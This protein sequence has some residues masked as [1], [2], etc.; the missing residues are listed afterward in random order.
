[1]SPSLVPLEGSLSALRPSSWFSLQEHHGKDIRVLQDILEHNQPV[2]R[3]PPALG[4]IQR[5]ETDPDP[6]SE[7]A[8]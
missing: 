2:H 3:P 1:M 4:V 7:H 6:A 5:S 8:Q